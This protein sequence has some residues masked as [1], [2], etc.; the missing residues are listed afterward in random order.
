MAEVR[1]MGGLISGGCSG[2]LRPKRMAAEKRQFW[3]KT[4]GGWVGGPPT[5]REGSR[6]AGGWAWLHE[7]HRATGSHLHCCLCKEHKAKN[8]LLGVQTPG[9]RGEPGV[10]LSSVRSRIGAKVELLGDVPNRLHCRLHC[11]VGSSTPAGTSNAVTRIQYSVSCGEDQERGVRAPFRSQLRDVRA[12]QHR[13]R[14][15]ACDAAASH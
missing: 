8:G 5:T 10:H 12:D 15:V 9:R 1:R 7:G 14:L 11:G 4:V 6:G 3:V 2:S 13:L